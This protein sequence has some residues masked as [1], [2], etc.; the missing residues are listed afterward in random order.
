M[1]E[2]WRRSG[3][4]VGGIVLALAGGVLTTLLILLLFYQLDGLTAVA[5]PL[6]L[7]GAEWRLTQGQGEATAAGLSIRQPGPQG[8]VVAQGS[9]RMMQAKLYRRLFWQV[10]GLA[11]DRELRLVWTTQ[12]EPRT[13]RE[14]VLPLAGPDGGALDLSAEPHWQGRIAMI[15]LMARGPLPQPLI[16]R[17]LELQPARLTVAEL[18]RRAVEDWTSF[19]DWSQRSINYTSGAP[20]D[21]LFPPVLIVALWIGFSAALYALFVPPR[22]RLSGLSPYAALF[23]LGWLTLDLR[24]QWDLTQRLER[25]RERFADKDGV[26]RRLAD[27]DGPLY[28][29]LGEVRQRLPEKPARLFIISNDPQGF[30]AGRARYHLLPHNGYAGLS[31]LPP[32]SQA[33]PGDYVLILSPL[34]AVAYNT[35]QRVLEGGKQR[36]PAEL[37]YAAPVGAL[38]RVGGD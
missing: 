38:F 20:L 6:I 36:L 1:T 9:A 35:A 7:T 25:T 28:R 13:P 4:Q 30:W 29:F 5:P 31:Q 2:S 14:R 26:E 32:A 11:P 16:I 10:D 3:R 23:L 8:W 15:G 22:W 27:L 34:A 37:L 12:A 18:W 33:R 21:A 19:E 17:R 24:W